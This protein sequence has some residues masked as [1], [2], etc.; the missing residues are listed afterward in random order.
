MLDVL[1]C[2]HRCQGVAKPL[3]LDD[4]C[5]TD[6]LVLAEGPIGKQV[7]FPSDL[8]RGIPE[9]IDFGILA[10]PVIRQLAALQD[11]LPAVV[12]QAQ[13]LAQMT[14]FAMAQDLASRDA[15]TFSLRCP[16][17]VLFLVGVACS[18]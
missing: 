1:L 8:V 14:L 5:V 13:L 7:P 6:P 15:C 18:E 17:A 10:G 9:L 11:D 2:F 3:V 12:D 4:G 16:S